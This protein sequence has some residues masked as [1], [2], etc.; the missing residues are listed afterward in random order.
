MINIPAHYLE[1]EH[2]YSATLARGIR[3]L[4]VVSTSP[5]EGVSSVILSL[6]K[7]N[8]IAGRK[9]LVVD[10]NIYNPELSALAVP[11]LDDSSTRKLPQPAAL[12][13]EHSA[14][15][16]AIISV[17]LERKLVLELREPGVLQTHIEQWLQDFDNVLFDTS[18]M[19]LTNG[20]NLPPE[21]ISSACDGTVLTV[22]AAST[23]NT[24]LTQTLKKLNNAQALLI[25]IVINDQFNP[26][27]K[28]ELLRE[29]ARLAP[30]F[31]TLANK[32][33][34]W[35]NNRKILALEI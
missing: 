35:L 7:R 6:A 3:S 34:T 23:T 19:S 15:D 33:T 25:G 8:I 11:G 2:I 29:V 28:H 14:R 31:P 20:A 16:V 12:S 13:P 32:L 24:S 1:L 18:P 30:I 27:L 21:Y 5:G 22:L 17:P 10:L 9:T 4:A 26:T